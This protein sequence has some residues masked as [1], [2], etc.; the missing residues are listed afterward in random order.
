[1]TTSDM[2][3]KHCKKKRTSISELARRINQSPQNLIKS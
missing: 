1:M 3:R 2:I